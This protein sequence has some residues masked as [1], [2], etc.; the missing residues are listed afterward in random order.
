M[1][2]QGSSHANAAGQSGEPGGGSPGAVWTSGA[3]YEAYIG[4][5]SRL[6]AREFLAW[7]DVPPQSR[8]LDVGCGSGALTQTILALAEPQAVTGLDVSAAFVA[9]MREQTPDPR[10]RFVV[11]DAR[12]IGEIADTYDAAVS[13]LMLNF[14]PEPER[15]VAGM[16]R[17]TRA[18]GTLAAYI[19]DYAG[20][21]EMMRAFWDTASALDPA[22]ADE[23]PRF[24]LANAEALRALF[25]SA[26][27]ADVA[28]QALDLAM[29]FRD[30]DD[31]WAP[32]LGGTGPAPHY[33][34]ALDEQHREA[35]R[36]ALRT[37]L[38]IAADG[39]ITLAARAWAVRGTR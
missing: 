20:R 9:Y 39:S 12:T 7:L 32:F 34:A 2:D 1:A 27:L 30:F 10:T 35:L 4:R 15:V 22:A 17:V 28:T 29:R 26:R 23:G 37:R 21:M 11:S 14:V 16:M 38:P 5:W 25:A 8:W 31:Y 33:V 13:G 19:W 3:A 36:E 6:L 24:S 18:G